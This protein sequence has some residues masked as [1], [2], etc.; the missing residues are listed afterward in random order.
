MI[1]STGEFPTILSKSILTPIYK[2]GDRHNPKNYRSISLIDVMGKVFTKI[3]NSR[4][5]HWAEINNRFSEAQCGYW[6]V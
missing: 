2:K 3:S 6:Q 5:V 1:L 4:I